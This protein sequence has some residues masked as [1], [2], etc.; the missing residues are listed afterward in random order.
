[1]AIRD[2]VSKNKA[3]FS[4]NTVFPHGHKQRVRRIQFSQNNKLMTTIS[5]DNVRLWRIGDTLIG[6]L[7]SIPLYKRYEEK[8]DDHFFAC[9]SNDGKVLVLIN[10][11]FALDI[12]KIDMQK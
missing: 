7:L 2:K 11:S 5:S 8:E 6:K 4:Q 9:I 10:G 12:V 3:I 1:M